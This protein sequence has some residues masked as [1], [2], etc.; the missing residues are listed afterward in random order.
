ML[1]QNTKQRTGNDDKDDQRKPVL[2]EVGGCGGGGA[3]AR[4]GKSQYK[5]QRQASSETHVA[6]VN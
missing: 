1:R 2:I 3:I 4:R 5:G 6:A